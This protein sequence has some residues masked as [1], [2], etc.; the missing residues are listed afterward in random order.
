MLINH[1]FDAVNHRYLVEGEFVLSTSAVIQLNGLSDM[2]SVP[3][4]NLAHA[5]SRG[6]MV[7]EAI[8]LSELN[9]K[10]WAMPIS[11]RID[12]L[13]EDEAP[14]G[15][16]V[17]KE[18][19]AERMGYYFKWRNS[20]S[21]KLI[22]KMEQSRVYRHIGTE[23]LIGATPDMPCLIDGEVYIIDTKTCHKAYGEK[24]KQLFL[25]WGLQLESY[26]ECL[27]SEEAFVSAMHKAGKSTI[28]R[29]ILH[30]HPECGKNGTKGEQSGYEFHTFTGDDSF[31]WDSA[32][33]MAKVKL[34]SGYKIGGIE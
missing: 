11:R 25:K 7:H 16:Q 5:G 18:E 2:A 23:Q 21:F 20:H 19:V 30:L 4:N 6:T 15:R 8:Y 1:Q 33:R 32:I 26:K 17:L 22:G 24:Q 28:N 3:K 34:A 27:E 31:I 13:P 29:A 12:L 10:N 14:F 9:P